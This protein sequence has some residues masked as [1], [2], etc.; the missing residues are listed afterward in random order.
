ME[1]QH[2]FSHSRVISAA[3]LKDL[4]IAEES[5]SSAIILMNAKLSELMHLPEINK[6]LFIHLD[7]LKGLKNDREG[8]AFL[9][10]FVNPTGIVTTKGNLIEAA[11][12]AG[13]LTIQ[14]IFLIDTTSLNT[15]IQN[16]KE[17]R[18]HAVEVMPGIAPSIVK[19]IKEELDLPIILA[20]LISTKEEIQQAFDAGAEAVSLSKQ[21]LWNE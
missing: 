16:I 15:A 13:L 4:K 3:Q 19:K 8:I 18:P 6:P 14:R 12:K 5:R 21:D 11:K 9:K 2:I 20:G 1:I 17:Y 7:L 10:E